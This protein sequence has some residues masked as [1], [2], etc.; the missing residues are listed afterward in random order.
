MK[1]NEQLLSALVANPA[2]KRPITLNDWESYVL[3]HSGGTKNAPILQI[4]RGPKSI[5]EVKKILSQHDSCI[6]LFEKR[7]VLFL[8][9]PEKSITVALGTDSEYER[10]SSILTR[11]N[12]RDAGTEFGL[13]RR[14]GSVIEAI[15][16]ST[17]D[18]DN[19]G[20]FSTHYLKNRMFGDARPGVDEMVGEVKSKLARPAA[21]ILRA[22]GWKG[23][24]GA[25]HDGGNAHIMITSQN[26]FSVREGAT[27]VPPSFTAIAKLK[28]KKWVIL[29]NG[30]KWRL[31]T[32]R[33]SASS[34]NYFELQLESPHDAVIKYLV[35]VFGSASY[36]GDDG[37][38]D[39]DGF[40]GASKTYAEGLGED[41]F[42]QIIT[43]DGLFLNIVKG[44]LNHDMKTIFVTKELD[45][46]KNAA[47]KIMYRLWFLAY[48]ESRD[49]LPTGDEKYR[50]LSLRNIHDR[51]DVYENSP[52]GTDCWVALLGLFEGIRKGSRQHNLPQYN[53]DLFAYA[54]Q[55]DN[56]KIR[57]GFIARALRGV[58]EKDGL[59]IDYSSLGVRHLGN[60]LENIMEFGIRQAEK[61]I[62]LLED[63][64]G[65]IIEVDSV[66]KSTYSYKKNDLYLASKGGIAARK[67]TASYYTPD[68]IVEFLVDRAL[69]PIF[70]ERKKLIPSDVSRYEKTGNDSDLHVCMDR[71]LDIQVLDPAM[72]SG[73]FLVEALN[74]ITVW[75]TDILKDHPGHPLLAELELER[76]AVLTEQKRNGIAINENLLTHDVLLKRKVMK[77]CIFGVDLNPMAVELAKM[78]LWLD[79]F[80]IG[81]PLTYMDHHIMVGDSTVGMFLDDLKDKNNQS[82]DDWVPGAKSD[83][84]ISDVI[85]NPDVTIFQVH[86]SED[87]YDRYVK[88]VRSG[89][90]ILDALT[91]SKIDPGLVKKKSS[92]EFIHRFGTYRNDEDE[93][94]RLARDTVQELSAK[95]RFFHWELGMR[96]A[97]TDA[98]RGFDCIVGNPPWDKSR[99]S[100]DEFFTQYD[101]TFKSL[102]LKPKKNA[103]KKKLLENQSICEKY[104]EY[105]RLLKEKNKFYLTYDIQGIGHKEL[106]KL[107]F[108]RVLLRL[109]AEN[110]TISMVLPTTI[111]SSEGTADMRK[112][113]LEKDI[114][115]LYV[116]ENREKIFQIHSSFRFML[117]SLRNADSTGEFPVGFYLHKPESLYDQTKE[118]DKFGN[119]SKEIISEMSPA[120]FTI[121]E[122]VESNLD[123]LRKLSGGSRMKYWLSDGWEVSISSGFNSG[124]D[125]DLFLEDGV[126]WPIYE[127]KAMH[128]Y[129]HLWNR[130]K[131]TADVRDG[132]ARES[133]KRTY[134]GM[135]EEFHNSYRLVFRKI[136][137]PTNMRTLVSTIIPP[138][139]FHTDSLISLVLKH[140]G[141]MVFD[142]DYNINISYMCGI[143]NSITFDF[144]ARASAQLNM[145]A[146]M[147]I[148]S[149]P[150]PIYKDRITKLVAKLTVGSPE[151]EGFAESM[152]IENRPLSVTKRINAVAEVDVLVAL[153]YGLT[154]EQYKAMLGSFKAFKENP[155]LYD[156]EKITWN[157]KN[158]KEFYGNMALRAYNMYDDIAKGEKHL[159]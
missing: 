62:M 89:V 76:M 128:Q 100:D 83:K 65:K 43:P 14:I 115:Q 121:P 135:H 8:K 116:F 58:L 143:F 60:I 117:L 123:M 81:V 41:L 87:A 57:N 70:E 53:G 10:V 23:V 78:S 138:H 7:D 101:P 126:G 67:S 158:L 122:V 96:D 86:A 93:D 104:Q 110:G 32:S 88:S 49:L 30:K 106:S 39:V 22:L 136:S 33:I 48:A 50:P 52:D 159:K 26:D 97:F 13:Q 107:V 42:T 37:K 153:S 29:T 144:M 24:M 132:L 27:D 20:L 5:S 63:K 77:K 72:G 108:E 147:K 40:L 80:A 137:S 84:M 1:P 113:I 148:L 69:G 154:K 6:I 25:H 114:S 94:L 95:H 105:I 102:N 75:A 118:N 85:S 64:S 17:G 119:M 15:P 131:Y 142:R 82:L 74:R 125:A 38:T 34:T 156:V 149:L 103:R 45:N 61:D 79:S 56:I 18:F 150:E 139:T 35:M 112:K 54:P 66:Q 146:V 55:V 2:E 46:A 129:N 36:Q 28:E 16:N 134:A 68:I 141:M 151:F 11:C 92:M 124:N 130:P 111:L 120:L 9:T 98:R 19:R 152:R 99:L 44:V 91:A 127:G 90:R 3:N 73:H 59:A 157:N 133:K 47:M 31:Y 4:V 109:I 51:L 21:D 71:L 140:D 155:S 145:P 12:V